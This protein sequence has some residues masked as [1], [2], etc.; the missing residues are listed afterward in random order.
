MPR[1]LASRSDKDSRPLFFCCVVYIEPH[2]SINFLN[3]LPIDSHVPTEFVLSRPAHH[4][5]CADV[6]TAAA[7]L[8]S[9]GRI[10]FLNR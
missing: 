6:Q 9:P 10:S 8:P 1:A 4:L 3:R 7:K 2:P 5:F